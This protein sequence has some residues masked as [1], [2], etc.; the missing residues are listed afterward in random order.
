MRHEV[1]ECANHQST[2]ARR[3]VR[4][5]LIFET[6]TSSVVRRRDRARHDSASSSHL[7]CRSE[8]SAHERTN[9]RTNHKRKSTTCDQCSTKTHANEPA[10]KPV[11]ATSRARM[12]RRRCAAAPGVTSA[13][14]RRHR[15]RSLRDRTSR[16]TLRF[17][18]QNVSKTPTR[19][20]GD[21]IDTIDDISTL[22]TDA[23]G[24]EVVGVARQQRNR[25]VASP[26]AC[27]CFDH[28]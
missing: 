17:G 24:D 11:R 25:R 28:R 14:H 21:E 8:A 15:A 3:H 22:I 10:S 23:E 19:N 7:T 2:I 6:W 18:E 13:S 26:L 16:A 20:I 27:A 4:F 9:G 12:R 1:R 5:D